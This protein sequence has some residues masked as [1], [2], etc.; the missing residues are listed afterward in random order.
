MSDESFKYLN[1]DDILYAY[2]AMIVMCGDIALNEDGSMTEMGEKYFDKAIACAK[3]DNEL[4][5]VGIDPN[6]QWLENLCREEE[7]PN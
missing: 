3:R 2:H 1:V 4:R 5:A 6:R 7:N